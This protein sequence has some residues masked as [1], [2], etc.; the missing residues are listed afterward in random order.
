MAMDWNMPA[1]AMPWN[2]PSLP[3][4]AAGVSGQAWNDTGLAWK[5]NTFTGI[6]SELRE[7][8]SQV[9]REDGA[10]VLLEIGQ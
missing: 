6:S 1:S 7:D 8:A 5:Q 2:D 3:W 9:L 4:K 10:R